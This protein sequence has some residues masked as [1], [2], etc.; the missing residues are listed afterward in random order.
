MLF[1]SRICGYNDRNIKG[2]FK[3]LKLIASDLDGTLLLN[4][5]QELNPEIYEIVMNIKEKGILF[6]SASGRQLNS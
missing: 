1:F 5:A 4:N 6:V 3:M 2:D